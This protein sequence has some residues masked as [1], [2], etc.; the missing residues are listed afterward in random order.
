[1]N[2]LPDLKAIIIALVGAE[3]LPF[4]YMKAPDQ[5]VELIVLRDTGAIEPDANDTAKEWQWRTFQVYIRHS[6]YPTATAIGHQIRNALHQAHD[7]EGEY[8][9]FR[10][11]LLMSEFQPIGQDE[12]GNYEITA[13]FKT[14]VRIK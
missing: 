9:E 8:H 6:D 7:Q 2:I 1:M 3:P 10:M 4:K 5:P 13:N 12:L 11:I 14:K